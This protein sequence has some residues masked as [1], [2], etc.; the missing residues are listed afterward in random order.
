MRIGPT[1]EFSSVYFLEICIP[2]ISRGK[3]SLNCSRKKK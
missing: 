2:F 3:L 1:S